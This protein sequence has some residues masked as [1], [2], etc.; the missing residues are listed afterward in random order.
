MISKNHTR[1]RALSR[2]ITQIENA[3]P[4]YEELMMETT[5]ATAK[6]IGITGAPGSGK[7]TLTD[8]LISE[9][10]ADGK[11]VAV[12][13][14]DPSSPFNRGAILGDRIRM[15]EWYNHPGVYIRSMASRGSLGG[16]HPRIVEVAEYVRQQEFDFVIIETVGVGQ[17]EVDIAALADLTIVVLVPEGGD[18]IQNMKSGLMEIADLFVVN[19]SDRPGAD[20]FYHDLK[21]MI[22]PAYKSTKKTLPVF[23]AVASERSG[24]ARLYQYIST[25][26]TMTMSEERKQLLLQKGFQILQSLMMEAVDKQEFKQQLL[27]EIHSGQVALFSFAKNYFEH[28]KRTATQG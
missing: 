3:L 21:K 4:G 16:L 22:G 17:S 25:A 18:S 26:D 8:A 23:Q 10:V 24:V 28:L 14:I 19:K 6:I 7:S 20:A 13:C 5:T 9:M 11:R 27:K 12:L 15:S 1:I 2:G